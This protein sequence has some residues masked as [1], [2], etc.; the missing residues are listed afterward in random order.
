MSSTPAVQVSLNFLKMFHNFLLRDFNLCQILWFFLNSMFEVGAFQ[1]SFMVKMR[2]NI[3]LPLLS[4]FCI[5]NFKGI[6]MYLKNRLKF[7]NF[8]HI[9][10]AFLL[11]K[12]SSFR[13]A[14]FL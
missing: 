12:V 11:S 8:V 13:V 4:L 2:R 9:P 14:A 1:V 7:K 5:R 6:S 3:N 10:F